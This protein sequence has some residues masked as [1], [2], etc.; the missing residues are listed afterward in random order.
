MARRRIWRYEEVQRFAPV[1]LDL[2]NLRDIFDLMN[3]GEGVRLIVTE[4]V[5]DSVDDLA[6]LR[7]VK[8]SHVEVRSQRPWVVLI[9]T[10]DRVDLHG[11]AEDPVAVERLKHL[12]HLLHRCRRKWAEFVLGWVSLWYL[13]YSL[14]GLVLVAYAT[15]PAPGDE[16]PYLKAAVVLF[17]TLSILGSIGVCSSA[18]IKRH[19]MALVF[20]RPAASQTF[21]QRNGDKLAVGSIL[22]IIGGI[23]SLAF[24]AVD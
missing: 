15:A 18:W 2:D 3:T 14:V 11:D 8:I 20:A 23:V 5:V 21:L 13:L 19:S 10:A 12:A 9:L 1:Q 22:A 7:D 24:S 6:D 17:S 16:D 4:Y